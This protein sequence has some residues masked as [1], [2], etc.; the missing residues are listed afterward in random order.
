MINLCCVSD[1]NFLPNGLALYES[2]KQ[3]DSNFTLHYLCMDD[4]SFE[5]LKELNEDIVAYPLSDFLNRDETLADLATQDYRYFC[6]SLASYF[7]NYLMNTIN[8]DITYIDSDILFY[9]KIET[10]LNE[11]GSKDVGLFRHRQYPLSHPNGNGWFNVGVIH[12]KNSD[13]ANDL[14]SWWAD[15]VLHKKYPELATCGDQKY[16]DAFLEHKENI[17]IDGNIGHGAPWHWQLYDYSSYFEDGCITWE[18]EKQKLIFSH[19]SDF[20]TNM[21]DNTYTAGLRHSGFTPQKAYSSVPELKF[22]HDDYFS[23]LKEI[24]KKYNFT[25]DSV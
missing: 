3:F 10:V 6:W 9:D 4:E 15:A 25:G 7:T 19:F 18:G 13:V 24:R 12:F 5:L 11:I 1:F 14:L 16:L 21:Q 22:I 8:E 23:K 2:M 17:F 20:D